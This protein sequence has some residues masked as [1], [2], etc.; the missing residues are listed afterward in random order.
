MSFN[1]TQYSPEEELASL[2]R[3]YTIEHALSNNDI[4]YDL[5]MTYNMAGF[6]N[7]LVNV[8]HGISDKVR[9]TYYESDG[10]AAVSILHYDGNIIR[11]VTDASRLGIDEYYDVSGYQIVSQ[12]ISIQGRVLEEYILITEDNKHVRIFHIFL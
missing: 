12:T 11:F 6:Y 9:I 10:S 2:P 3:D 1:F 7:F 5:N 4:V 8:N